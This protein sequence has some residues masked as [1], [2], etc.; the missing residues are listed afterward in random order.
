MTT[1]TL[2]PTNYATNTNHA[3]PTDV[4]D[5]GLLLDYDLVFKMLVQ[6]GGHMLLAKELV[7]KHYKVPTSMITDLHM[8]DAV[9][10]RLPELKQYMEVISVLELFS[11]MPVMSKT[12]TDTFVSQGLEPG[13]AINAFMSLHKLISAKVDIQKIDVNVMNEYAWK[14]I[15]MELRQLWAMSE[16]D[17]ANQA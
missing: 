11:L 16:A 9:K 15:P 10:D 7:A 17:E 13:D 6:C 2:V 12:L 5:Q 8:V 3:T 4:V 1:L 14:N